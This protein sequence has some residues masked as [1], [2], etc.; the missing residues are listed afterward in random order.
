MSAVSPARNRANGTPSKIACSGWMGRSPRGRKTSV[1]MSV[2]I[3]VP[4]L[5]RE[6]RGSTKIAAWMS[7]LG[8]A[9]AH[10]FGRLVAAA[11]A[12]LGL[13]AGT[14][15]RIDGPPVV[16]GPLQHRRAHAA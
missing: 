7:G 8:S 6:E 1:T 11:G 13:D 16:E 5:S 3:P 14:D 2:A 10:A 9:L 12:D 4:P 15:V